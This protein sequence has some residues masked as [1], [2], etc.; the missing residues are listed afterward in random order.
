MDNNL[1]RFPVFNSRTLQPLKHDQA[2]KFI[3]T[4]CKEIGLRAD[5]GTHS[6]RKPWGFHARMQ[7]GLT[8]IVYKLN[9]KESIAYTKRYPV[10]IIMN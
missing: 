9:H 6:M 8:L 5:Y 7:G 2:L 1:K 10:I 4:I 3:S